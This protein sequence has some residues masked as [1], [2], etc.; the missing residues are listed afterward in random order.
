M[1]VAELKAET[2][3]VEEERDERQISVYSLALGGR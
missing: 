3:E 2:R 1:L